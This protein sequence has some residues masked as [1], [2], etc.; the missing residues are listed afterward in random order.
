VLT[1]L[2]AAFA[3]FAALAY[4]QTGGF[5]HPPAFAKRW[6]GGRESL[7][8]GLYPDTVEG[9]ARRPGQRALALA[10][11]PEPP[12]AAPLDPSELPTIEPATE[13][14]EKPNSSSAI[15]PPRKRRSVRKSAAGE[16]GQPQSQRAPS[17]SWRQIDEAL[18]ANDEATARRLLKQLAA[19]SEDATTQAKARLGLAQ[20]ALARGDCKRATALARGI[21]RS[22]GI[23]EKIVKRAHDVVLKCD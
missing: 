17:S 20:M 3:L 16:T 22:S 23:D 15:E 10:P 21:A 18:A 13:P 6:S 14:A 7:R 1:V 4:G 19:N 12:S 11:V 8:T 5:E 2:P 9:V